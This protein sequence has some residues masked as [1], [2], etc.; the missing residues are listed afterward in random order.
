MD[1]VPL[2]HEYGTQLPCRDM[3]P[4]SNTTNGSD[5]S[6]PGHHAKTSDLEE[7]KFVKDIIRQI[8]TTTYKCV[9]G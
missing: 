9:L 2:H 7:F 1:I 8:N 5:H 6:Q 4:E 3:S